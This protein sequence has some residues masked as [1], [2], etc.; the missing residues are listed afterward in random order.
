MVAAEIAVFV[1]APG[2]RIHMKA[3]TLAGVLAV[4]AIVDTT[5]TPYAQTKE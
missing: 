3:L 2:R 1:Y 5:T 4:V